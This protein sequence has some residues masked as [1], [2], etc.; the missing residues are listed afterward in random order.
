MSS[1]FGVILLFVGSVCFLCLIAGF[2][3]GIE[4]KEHRSSKKSQP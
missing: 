2:V 4:Y 3:L 1:Y